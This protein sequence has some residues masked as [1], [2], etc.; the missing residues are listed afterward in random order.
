MKTDVYLTDRHGQIVYMNRPAKRQV[1]T[2]NAIR[3]A[4]SH[5]APIDRKACLALDRAINEATGDEA[6]LPTSGFTI[7]LPAGDNAG[8]IA[9][10]LPLARC[11]AARHM[12]EGPEFRQ[13]ADFLL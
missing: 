8:L 12:V 1:D 10:V 4:N 6:D 11:H 13:Q 7:A 3:V 2:T 5:L 9:T